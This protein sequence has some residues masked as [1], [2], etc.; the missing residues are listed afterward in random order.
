[1]TRT[2]RHLVFILAL[3][4]VAVPAVARA[5][6]FTFRPSPTTALNSL[7]HYYAYEWQ[8]TGFQ[9]PAGHQI[10]SAT[11]L[12]D[13]IYNWQNESFTLYTRLLDS[14]VLVSQPYVNGRVT[15]FWDNQGGGDYFGSYG[16]LLGT[17]TGNKGGP[18]RAI[19]LTYS[20]SPAQFGFLADGTF[21]FGI[22]PDCHF[23]DS[24]VTFTVTTQPIATPEPASMI[25]LGSGLVG[26]A[27]VIR[28]RKR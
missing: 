15:S 2:A 9:L 10:A 22:D 18:G 7:D 17:W 23:Y 1:M 13:N 11:L 6:T 12:Y 28:R 25:L 3:A 4:F 20:V 24:G 14:P 27:S 19:D 26:L 16:V 8:I 5:D 21:A